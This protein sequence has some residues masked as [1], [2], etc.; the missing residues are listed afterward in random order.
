MNSK[1]RAGEEAAAVFLQKKGYRILER[2]YSCRYGEID[3]IAQK[4]Q[5]L[6]F[7]EVKERSVSGRMDPAETVT[8]AKQKRIWITAQIYMQTNMP[9]ALI[10]PRFDVIAVYKQGE[11]RILRHLENA[12]QGDGWN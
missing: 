2:N 9:D 4:E 6:V 5:V 3:L 8:K 10:Q 11:K 7:A 12:F 1:G